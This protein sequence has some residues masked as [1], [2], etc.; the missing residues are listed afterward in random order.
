MHSP[1]G[2][3]N[4]GGP[5]HLMYFFFHFENDDYFL[6]NGPNVLLYDL[7]SLNHVMFQLMGMVDGSSNTEE[8]LICARHWARCHRQ[9]TIQNLPSPY[10]HGVCGLMPFSFL[11]LCILLLAQ[12]GLELPPRFFCPHFLSAGIKKCVSLCVA[13]DWPPG[14]VHA[15]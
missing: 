7:L 11:V 9:S 6:N 2:S 12:A 15:W 8:R 14:S 4:D 10:L 1:E 13:G 3:R 5:F